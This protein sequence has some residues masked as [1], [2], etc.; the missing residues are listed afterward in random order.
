MG[1]VPGHVVY[2]AALPVAVSWE[3]KCW[4][5]YTGLLCVAIDIILG[6]LNGQIW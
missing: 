1:G 5:Q 6:T 2:L 3:N 4:L